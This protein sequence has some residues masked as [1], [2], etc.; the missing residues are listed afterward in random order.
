MIIYH[1]FMSN[2]IILNMDNVQTNRKGLLYR[3]VLFF[4]TFVWGS[5]V[6][7]LFL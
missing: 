3:T 1:K 2:N 7:I 4:E 6:F 5:V